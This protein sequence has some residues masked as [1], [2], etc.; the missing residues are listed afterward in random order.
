MRTLLLIAG[1]LL[2]LAMTSA[3]LAAE[4]TLS[5]T[6]YAAD[7]ALV[8]DRRDIEVK[9]GRQRIEFQDVSAQ[10]RPETV[11]LTASDISIV[12][13]NFDFDL[14]TPAKLMEKAVGQDITSLKQA[15]EKALQS[16]RLAAIGQMMA[17]KSTDLV[18]APN[19]IL[20]VPTSGTKKTLK[21]LG[22]VALS[23]VNGIAFY[24]VGYR[25]GNV[26]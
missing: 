4:R 5:V 8:Q 15:Q 22:D 7:L 11:S 1:S 26:K 21:V 12:E 19:D 10:I 24:G 6:I 16:E 3:A 2:W 14:L 9:S 25:V 18:L 17:G 23:A 13:Q 20:F